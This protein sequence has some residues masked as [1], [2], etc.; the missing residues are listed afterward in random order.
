MGKNITG[1]L[2]TSTAKR[3]LQE[4]FAYLVE[5][6]EDAAFRVINKILDKA[7]ILIGDSSG[8]GQREPLLRHKSVVYRY[9]V[10]GNYKII[11]SV[12]GNKVVIH[13][14]F[15][16]RQNPKKMEENVT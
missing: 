2:W 8:I 6:S 1:I 14:V 4:T 13:S 5:F 16:A 12:N 9:L 3:D 7:G 10:E 15:D 11:Y